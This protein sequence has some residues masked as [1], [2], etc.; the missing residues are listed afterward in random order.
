MIFY[1]TP[2]AINNASESS[3]KQ[4]SNFYSFDSQQ[5]TLFLAS[6]SGFDTNEPLNKFFIQQDLFCSSAEA[7][8]N[9]PS[10]LESSMIEEDILELNIE[11]LLES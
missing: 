6:S 4:G 1:I 9:Q 7:L 5:S 10:I 3:F 11:D 8:I 2:S